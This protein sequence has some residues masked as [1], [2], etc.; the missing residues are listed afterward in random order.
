MFSLVPEGDNTEREVFNLLQ[1]HLRGAF[2]L[3]L[4]KFDSDL[5]FLQAC[6]R[7]LEPKVTRHLRS[8]Y[9]LSICLI[10]QE[11]KRLVS[12]SFKR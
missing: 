10:L 1:Q 6:I 3:V 11:R 9:V 2:L 4:M 12:A 7:E 5:L 8:N